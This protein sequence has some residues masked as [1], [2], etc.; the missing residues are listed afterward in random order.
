MNAPAKSKR[1]PREVTPCP[2]RNA[3]AAAATAAATMT[4]MIV[5]FQCR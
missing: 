3:D 5:A 4:Q 2:G 1:H